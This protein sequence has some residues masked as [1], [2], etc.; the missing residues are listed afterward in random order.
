MTGRGASLEEVIKSLVVDLVP[1]GKCLLE[2]LGMS[3]GDRS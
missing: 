1:H 2:Q 3:A